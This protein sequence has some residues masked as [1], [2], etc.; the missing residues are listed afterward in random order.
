M[1]EVENQAAS[2]GSASWTGA[3]N[4]EVGGEFHERATAFFA[5]VKWDVLASASSSLRNG[6]P[7]AFGERFSI[8]NFNLVRQIVFEDGVRWVARLRLPELK[9]V[10]GGREALDIAST[11]KIEISTMKFFRC[12]IFGLCWSC[13]DFLSLREGPKPLFLFQKFMATT[14]IQLMTLVPHTF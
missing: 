10:F 8:G 2:L 7:C 1:T 11:L 12:V 13:A 9:A 3:D 6:I 5:A 4:Y 14:L